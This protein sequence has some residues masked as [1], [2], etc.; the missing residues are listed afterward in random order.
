MLVKEVSGIRKE[1]MAS[2]IKSQMNRFSR[3]LNV[4]ENDDSV[5]TGYVDSSLKEI[6]HSLRKIRKECNDN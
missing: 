2:S 5:D 6:E 3:I 4:I 1:F